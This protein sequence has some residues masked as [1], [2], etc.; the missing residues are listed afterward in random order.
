N[1]GIQDGYR[2]VLPASLLSLQDYVFPASAFVPRGTS[3]INIRSSGSSSNTVWFAP[4]GT[5]SFVEGAT[6]TKAAGEA[7]S[8]GVPANAGT[9]KLFIVNAQGNKLGES[10]AILQ[11]R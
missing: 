10:A 4:A 11:V 1:S 7:T 5:T 3:S 8:I 6:M 9:Y 2:S